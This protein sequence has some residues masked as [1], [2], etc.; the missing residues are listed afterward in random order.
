VRSFSDTA[1]LSLRGRPSR[2]RLTVISV[3]IECLPRAALKRRHVLFSGLVQ[4]VAL[5]VITNFGK[6]ALVLL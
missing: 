3:R 1:S 5:D 2:D 6:K 4:A